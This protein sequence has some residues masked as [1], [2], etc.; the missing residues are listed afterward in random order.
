MPAA[1]CASGGP[2]LTIRNEAEVTK[3]GRYASWSWYPPAGTVF[4]QVAAQ[5]HIAHDAGHRAYYAITDNA[6]N[7]QQRWPREGGLRLRGLGRGAHAVVFASFLAC[8]VPANSSCG[9][10]GE[11]PQQRPQPLV[12]AARPGQPDAGALGHAAGARDAPRPAGAGRGGGGLAAGSGA[13]GS[14]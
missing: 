1:G 9:P 11:G 6:G 10:L 14:K 2:G 7:V 5:S 13:G 8:A 12:H 4:T 3:P